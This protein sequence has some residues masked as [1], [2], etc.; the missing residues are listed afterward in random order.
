MLK[1][2]GTIPLTLRV[3]SLCLLSMAT[4]NGQGTNVLS[5]TN[6]LQSAWDTLASNHYIKAELSF[7]AAVLAEPTNA[8][9]YAGL[10]RSQYK[11][12]EYPWAIR[13]LERALTLQPSHTN[14]LL[15]LGESYCLAGERSKATNILQRYVSLCTNDTEGYV[16]LSYALSQMAQYDG[17]VSAAKHALALNPTNNWCYRQLGYGLEHLNRHDDAIQAFRHALTINPQDGDAYLGCAF[18]LLAEGRLGEATT[19]IEKACEI[20][21]NN[22]SA[23]RLL[24]VCYLG[25]LQYEKAYRLFPLAFAIGVCAT[26]L[27]YLTGLAILLP[28]SFRVRSQAF[29]GIV[30]SLTWLAVYFE[31]QLVLFLI[32]GLLFR[33]KT[34]E[35]LLAGVILAGIPVLLAWMFGFRQQPWGKPFAWPLQLGTK[36]TIGLCL[37]GLVLVWLFNW[38]F[39]EMVERITHQPAPV[40]ETVLLIKSALKT[41]PLLALL[42]VVIL[43]PVVEEILVRGLLYGALEKRLPTGGTILVTSLIFALYHFDMAF[44]IPL[45]GVGLLLGWARAKTGS[46]GLPIL[47]HMLNNGLSLLLVKLVENGS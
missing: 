32:L 22:G 35:S 19:N 12:E 33:I 44:F 16:W 20:K 28:L 24:F 5:P 37:L 26:M 17:A 15:Y 10:G 36:K 18:S 29:P 31:G 11:L 6:L 42:A 1:W 39:L 34:T 23:Q 41:S 45:F 43:G 7:H 46:I 3:G 4:L 27:F 30:F 8:E 47:I 40:Q 14:W 2:V 21:K 9:A 25:S 13:N 38:A